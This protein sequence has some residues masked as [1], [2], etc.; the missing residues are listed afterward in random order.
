M[1]KF[2]NK[3]DAVLVSIKSYI[4]N[5]LEKSFQAFEWGC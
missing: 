5:L 3:F 4:L 1:Y 2:L